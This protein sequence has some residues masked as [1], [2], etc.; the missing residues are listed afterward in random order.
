MGKN[1]R[2]KSKNRAKKA[3]NMKYAE[4]NGAGRS[5]KKTAAD[6]SPAEEKAAEDAA[7]NVG[8]R[9]G[10]IVMAALFLLFIFGF[11]V[12][13][14]ISPDRDFSQMENRSLE[15]FPEFS[16]EKLKKGEFTE[17]LEKYMSDQ[18][19]LKD[20]LVTLKTDI[21]RAFGKNLQNGVYFAKDGYILQQYL[22]NREVIDENI[23]YINDFAQSVDIPVDMILVPNAVEQHK[24][25]LPPFA[26]NDSQAQ[27]AEHIG[28]LLGENV[29]LYYMDDT[30]SYYR[31]DHHWTSEGAK[32]AFEEYL[33]RSGQ[34][35]SD[36]EYNVETVGGFYGTLY[37]KAPSA[38][39]K[40]DELHLYTNPDGE[41]K[42]EYVKENK[43]ADTVYEREFLDK[44]DKYSVFFGGNFSQVR[45]SSN[46]KSGEKVL[47]LKDSYAN[48]MMPFIIDRYSE[49]TMID[50]RYYHFEENTV[51][52]LCELY[53]ADSDRNFIWLD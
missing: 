33:E 45:I 13:G 52:Q 37:S 40:P 6:V 8:L 17:D 25:K 53:G 47:V 48:A 39:T 9:A 29:S 51:S 20:S 12:A 32:K 36:A 46:A 50:M 19:F 15:Q 42:V 38:F 43:T 31:T 4:N 11:A 28:Q 49:V 3:R 44:K 18:V 7:V 35:K 14:F 21:D 27:S 1:K 23:G 5:L 24:D 22:E 34:E 10:D 26:V 2:K 30:D 41:Y 16:F